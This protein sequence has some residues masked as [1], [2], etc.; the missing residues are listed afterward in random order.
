VEKGQVPARPD[1]CNI[2]LVSDKGNKFT[3][4][5]IL[6]EYTL[7]SGIA[8][9]PNIP[10]CKL[11]L[12]Y[13]IDS[14]GNLT[15]TTK[16]PGVINL[17]MYDIRGRTLLKKALFS[18]PSGSNRFILGTHRRTPQM[19]LYRLRYTNGDNINKIIPMK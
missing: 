11:N 8:R 19:L 5:R 13:N 2:Y 1:W 12:V 10:K 9:S 7:R 18:N 3:K 16:K 17:T 14:Q 15:Y 6:D 4:G